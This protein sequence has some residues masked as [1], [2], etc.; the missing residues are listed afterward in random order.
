M[1]QSYDSLRWG[2]GPAWSKI[3]A[4][5]EPFLLKKKSLKVK[6]NLLVSRERKITNEKPARKKKLRWAQ[7]KSVTRVQITVSPFNIRDMDISL[8]LDKGSIKCDL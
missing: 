1:R 2:N 8:F 7:N 5:G 4:S 3:P 6:E